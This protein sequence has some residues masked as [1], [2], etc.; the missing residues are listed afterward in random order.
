ML[1]FDTNHNSAKQIKAKGITQASG[2][3]VA[4]FERSVL[5]LSAPEP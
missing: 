1:L 2:F 4:R 5:L 3:V